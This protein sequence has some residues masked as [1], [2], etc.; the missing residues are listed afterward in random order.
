MKLNPAFAGTGKA[1]NVVAPA[2]TFSD[3]SAIAEPPCESNLYVTLFL[4]NLI[5]ISAGCA[6]VFPDTVPFV[7][8]VAG[9]T[10]SVVATVRGVT[11]PEAESNI[12]PVYVGIGISTVE[13]AADLNAIE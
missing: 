4:A 11:A 12:Y 2:V 3:L 7:G 9:G 13:P 1:P 6:G 10:G 8:V 5:T